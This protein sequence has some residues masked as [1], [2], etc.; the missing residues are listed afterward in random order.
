M[1]LLHY[2]AKIL[3]I[4]GALNWGLVGFFHFNLVSALLGEMSMLA[5]LVYVLVGVSGVL[6]LFCCCKKRCGCCGK[7]CDSSGHCG[8]CGKD[9]HHHG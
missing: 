1:R 3:V 4:V 5:R 8:S 7:S 9:H 6:C 2:I